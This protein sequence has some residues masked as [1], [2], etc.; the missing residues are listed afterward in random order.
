[1]S[2]YGFLTGTANGALWCSYLRLFK[3]KTFSSFVYLFFLMLTKAVHYN[4]SCML[5]PAVFQTCACH[6]VTSRG[7]SG[8]ETAVLLSKAETANLGNIWKGSIYKGTRS[9][10]L[11]SSCGLILGKL[12]HLQGVRLKMYSQ[13]SVSSNENL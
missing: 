9:A 5:H 1:M 3:I 7:Y 2:M 12:F 4:G 13:D 11:A 8:G 10:P 6:D